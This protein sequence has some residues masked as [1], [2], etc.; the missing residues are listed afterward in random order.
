MQN[1]E[2]H[3]QHGSMRLETFRQEANILR[4]LKALAPRP[5]KQPRPR[6]QLKPHNA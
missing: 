1:L 2:M 6:G 3:M 5:M 4:Q